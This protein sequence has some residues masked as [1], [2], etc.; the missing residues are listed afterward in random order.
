MD[1]MREIIAG[2]LLE[3]RRGAIPICVM[4][5]LTERTYG[6]LLVQRLEEKGFRVEANTLYPL[7]RRLE[8]QKLLDS[9]WET[10]GPKP[11]KYYEL[12]AVGREVYGRL[13][14]QWDELR[15][16]MEKIMGR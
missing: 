5:Q 11:R 12:S 6:Y 13:C 2:L 15:G 9:K 8:K 16:S 3:L 7:L 1:E 10:S 4:S 14:T